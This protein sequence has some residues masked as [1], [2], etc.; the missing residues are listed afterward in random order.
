[1]AN[2]N[3]ERIINE[4][5]EDR[6]A[7]SPNTSG[8]RR[9]AVEEVLDA[10]DKGTLMVAVRQ[11]NGEWQVN[12]WV[13]KA[14]LLSFKFNKNKSINCGEFVYFDKVPLKFTDFDNQDF[15]NLKISN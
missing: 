5:W 9:D 12:Q 1:M 2:T 13:K 4:V 10:L 3:L 7:I 11:D 6:E 14:V 8:E 15:N